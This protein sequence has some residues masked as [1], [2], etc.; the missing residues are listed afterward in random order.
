MTMVAVF[1]LGKTNAKLAV[2]DSD[3]RL[4]ETLSTA[5][6][7]LPGP[8]YAHHDVAALEGWLLSGLRTLGRS[9]A[10]DA[11]VTTAH[12]SGGVLVGDHGPIMPM[13]DYEQIPPVDVDATYR[14]IAGS[15]RERG[16]PI[17]LGTA[18]LARQMLWL[19]MHW[20]DIFAK[21]RYYLTAP[22][23]W[24]WRLS[25]VA[26]GEVTSLA[27]QSHLWCAVEARQSTIVAERGWSRLLPD[28]LPAWRRIGR[29]KPEL[30]AQ[31]GLDTAVHIHCGIHDSSANFYRYQAAGLTDITVVSSGTWIAAISDRGEVPV[32]EGAGVCCNADVHGR[33]LPG[34][35][36]MAGREFTAIRGNSAEAMADLA[37]LERLVSTGTMALP[38]FGS[39][40]GLFPG[41][42]GKGSIEGPLKDDGGARG[43]LGV[44]YSALLADCC[45]DGSASATII[46]DGSF[47][48]DPLYSS[49]IGALNPGCSVLVNIDRYGTA[50]GAALLASHETRVDPAPLHVHPPSPLSLPGLAEYRARWRAKANAT[51]RQQR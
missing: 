35:L 25:G 20:P 37:K 26:A 38:T 18:H 51:R 30:A 36:T 48:R 1:D 7:V 50:T 32:S 33:P 44:L 46:L 12:G 17:M 5:N 16:S 13:I 31:T 14:Q 47:V 45:L 39:D 3:G 27:A 42:A 9:H 29:L 28:L 10:F 11:I 19:E 8:P 22:Q 49:L 43:T 2:A 24:A 41:T 4:I 6:P 40:E 15:F 34:V 23:Y 21:A